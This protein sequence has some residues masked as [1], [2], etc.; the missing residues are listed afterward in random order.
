[1][2]EHVGLGTEA[3]FWK[4]ERQ[5]ILG[6]KPGKGYPSTYDLKQHILTKDIA[7]P[8]NSVQVDYGY[9]NCRNPREREQWREVYSMMF[10]AGGFRFDAL[11][12]ACITG[13]IYDYVM[14][15]F[16]D[17]PAVFERLSKNLYL[18]ASA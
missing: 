9:L 15:I 1:M 18:L 7:D 3:S 16:P 5:A 10:Q 12:K 13:K 2:A 6:L 14:E 17:T 8:I 4:E 11:H